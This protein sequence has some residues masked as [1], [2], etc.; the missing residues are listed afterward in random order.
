MS[1]PYKAENQNII[2]QEETTQGTFTL[3]FDSADPFGKIPEEVE[4]PDVEFEY[5]EQYYTGSGNWTPDEKFKGQRDVSG[6]N[7]VVKP[8]DASAFK[9][10]I[11]TTPDG[12]GNMRLSNA[13]SQDTLPLSFAL[14]ASYASVEANDEGDRLF[15]GCVVDSADITVNNDQELEIDMDFDA[16]DVDNSVTV[17]GDGYNSVTNLPTWSFNDTV[18]NLSFAGIEFAR[19]QDFTLSIERNISVDFY[20]DDG[21]TALEITYGRPTITVDATITVSDDAILSELEADDTFTLNIGF[22]NGT[23]TLDISV[24]NCNIRSAPH[25]LPE[26]GKVESDVEIVG[27]DV[28]VTV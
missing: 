26:E 21:E 2:I 28:V 4:L 24:E 17:E 6:G 15:T 9:Y 14:G 23:N 20:V 11:G 3:P 18:S 10:I 16:L 19:L 12:S 27:E 13:K 22:D 1:K 5:E 25:P 8:V 7:I